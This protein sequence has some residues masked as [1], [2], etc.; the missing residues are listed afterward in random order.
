MCR[1][2]SIEDNPLNRR[3]VYDLLALSSIDVDEAASGQGGIELAMQH[4]YDGI[5]LDLDLGDMSGFEVIRTLRDRNLRTPII[6]ASARCA[7]DARDQSL[8]AGATDYIAKPFSIM[9]FRQ[10]VGSAFHILA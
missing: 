1:V 10:A 8:R 3:L 9:Q 2:L 5:I 4:V 7:R 6:V